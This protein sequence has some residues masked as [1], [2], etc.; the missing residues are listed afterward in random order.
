MRLVII[1]LILFSS[2]A[3]GE[4]YQQLSTVN[5]VEVIGFGQANVQ[6]S[7]H[8]LDIVVSERSVSAIK[9]SQSIEYKTKLINQFVDKNVNSIKINSISSLTLNMNYPSLNNTIDD[10]D[11]FTKLPNKR[12]VK[13]NTKLPA[14]HNDKGYKSNSNNAVVEASLHMVIRVTDID[15]YQRLIDHLMKVGVNDV[16]TMGVSRVEHQMAYQQALN[17]ALA[18]AKFKAKKMVDH[19]DISLAEVVAVQEMNVEKSYFYAE[20]DKL[21]N[22]AHNEQQSDERVVNAQVKVI[23]AIKPR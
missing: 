21:K 2:M 20:A 6:T 7:T 8:L 13:V 3:Y 1:L 11:F 5:G 18:D 12:A 16:Q 23:F 10:V 17:N 14:E 9:A 4:S 22:Y 15:A 19:L